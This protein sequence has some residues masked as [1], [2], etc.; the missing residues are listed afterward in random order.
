MAKLG[1]NIKTRINEIQRVVAFHQASPACTN[2]VAILA[3]NASLLIVHYTIRQE[4]NAVDRC[5][6]GYTLEASSK[7]IKQDA[8]GGN[9]LFLIERV[10]GFAVEVLVVFEIK[11]GVNADLGLYESLRIDIQLEWLVALHASHEYV[12]ETALLH[13]VLIKDTA[14]FIS[15]HGFSLVIRQTIHTFVGILYFIMNRPGYQAIRDIVQI[16]NSID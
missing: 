3:F 14:D 2:N 15:L 6:V 1:V 5:V 13:L 4:T 10:E 16:A 8:V 11:G 12:I 9:A 7:L